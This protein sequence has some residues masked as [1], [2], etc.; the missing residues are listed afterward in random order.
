MKY[1]LVIIMLLAPTASGAEISN[2]IKVVAST[3]L[4]EA[5]GE[6]EAGMYAVACVISQRS[7]ERKISP[8]KVCLQPKQFAC[9]SN[10]V[11]YSLLSTPQ[12]QYAIRL[13]THLDKLDRSSVGYANHYHT[14]SIS[15]SWSK[16]V[17]PVTVIRNHKFFKL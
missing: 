1:I 4:A 3:I 2:D 10:G 16:G 15:P 9:N 13:A 7:I 11:Q 17:T 12:A 5:R 6:G 8:A 14:K